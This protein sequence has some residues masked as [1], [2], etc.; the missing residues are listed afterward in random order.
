M[1][2][3]IGKIFDIQR[4]SVHDGPGIRTI[5]FM[6]GCPLYCEWCCNPE[7]QNSFT[8]IS[9]NLSDCLKCEKCI[10][11]CPYN[12]I[13]N[14]TEGKIFDSE[15]CLKCMSKD[16]SVVCPSKAISLFGYDITV[17]ELIKEIEKDELFY[18]NSGGGIT[19][20]GGE[21][22]FQADFVVELLKVCKEYNYHTAIETS[23][24]CN[25]ES[26]EKVLPYTDLFLC[27]VKHID[28]VKMKSFT[29]GDISVIN[30]NLRKL[31]EKTKNI[32]ARVPVIPSFNYDKETTIKIAEFIAEL[33]INEVNLLPYH[34]YGKSKYEKLFREYSFNTYESV[35]REAL[36]EFIDIFISL[37]IKAKIGG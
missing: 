25:W 18:I 36:E 13:S 5:I 16:C 14:L 7:S 31:S 2:N 29:G 30:D 22:L 27:D 23:S 10:D 28:S 8:D 24:Y 19:I 32:I 3:I 20:S 37:N 34:N 21:P 15:K 1:S 35:K 11:V 9:Y 12:V 4:F 17:N 33:G 26:F 6:K